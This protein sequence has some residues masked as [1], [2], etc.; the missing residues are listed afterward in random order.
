MGRGGFGR[1]GLGRVGVVHGKLWYTAQPMDIQVVERVAQNFS[2]VVVAV[3]FYYLAHERL[4]ER[5]S[6]RDVLMGIGFGVTTA[7]SIVLS[8]PISEGVI[9]DAKMVLGALAGVF[10]GV[11]PATLT[12]VI[13]SAARGALGGIGTIPGVAGMVGAAGAGVALHHLFVERSRRT[14]S[15]PPGAVL[16]LAPGVV[17]VAAQLLASL[18]FIPLAGSAFAWK[19]LALSI[20][21]SIVVYI[22]AAA[23]IAAMMLFVDDRTRAHREV[24]A[25]RRLLEERVRTRTGQL[26]AA[27]DQLVQQEKLASLGQLTGGIAHSLNTPLGAAAS[28]ER[29]QARRLEGIFTDVLDVYRTLED[30]EARAFRLLFQSSNPQGL[31][32]I[33]SRS[34]RRAAMHLLGDGVLEGATWAA[35]AIAE[36]HLGEKCPEELRRV[37]GSPRG[38]Q[39]LRALV[40][41]LEVRHSGLLVRRAAGQAASTVAA[42]QVYAQTESL[43]P[44]QRTAPAVVLEEVLSFLQYRIH[45]RIT[46]QL[47]IDEAAAVYAVPSTIRQIWLILV[48]NALDAMENHGVLYL[49][50]EQRASSVFLAVEDTGP[51]VSR[52]LRNR[53]FEPFFTTRSGDAALGLGLDIARR[54]VR[55]LGGHLHCGEPHHGSG[56]RFEVRLP[57]RRN[58]GTDQGGDDE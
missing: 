53:I 31:S 48:T 27:R 46:V 44:P 52:E 3:F 22:P 11:V 54:V 13:A 8:I 15:R 2:L 5:Q 39:I 35:E 37:A 18:V 24:E 42:L 4:T 21:P 45:G 55:D 51:G 12:V 23:A 7:I 1:V 20:V 38:E 56:A 6:Q 40:A 17:A 43:E 28:A 32:R 57:M 47:E 19:I 10:G 58:V 33:V 41:L 29:V 50:V 9:L 34:D 14:A 25:G 26:H 36:F 30:E 49:T 16:L